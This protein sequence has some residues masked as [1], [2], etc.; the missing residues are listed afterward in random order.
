MMTSQK[1]IPT[2]DVTIV[3]MRTSIR[4][5]E[6]ARSEMRLR[7]L[8]PADTETEAETGG[9]TKGD[10]I[11]K[12]KETLLIGNV[13]DRNRL[14]IGLTSTK[15]AAPMVIKGHAEEIAKIVGIEDA[16]HTLVHPRNP[17]HRLHTLIGMTNGES[18]EDAVP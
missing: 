2:D 4:D 18:T 6:E 5:G 10:T 12:T 11:V 1:C 17:D 13:N 8:H 7:A 9:I 16:D 15:E 14:T 3:R